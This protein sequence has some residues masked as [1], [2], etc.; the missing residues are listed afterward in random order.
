[1]KVYTKEEVLDIIK[2]FL[3][4]QYGGLS[5]NKNLD[6]INTPYTVLGILNEAL[7]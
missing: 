3:I 2:A 5:T 7:S 6:E 1:M 4:E